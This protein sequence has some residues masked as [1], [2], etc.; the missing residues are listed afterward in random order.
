MEKA[1]RKKEKKKGVDNPP[2]WLS[3]HSV[4]T[5]RCQV[6][7]WDR[8]TLHTDSAEQADNRHPRWQRVRACSVTQL[9]PTLRPLDC[10]LSDSSVGGIFQARI[11]EWVAISFSTMMAIRHF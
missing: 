7:M 4:S 9:C 8:Q 3:E 1:D 11:L 2:P 10:S 5:L 6:M